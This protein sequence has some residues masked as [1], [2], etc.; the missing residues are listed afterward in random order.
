MGRLPYAN[1]GWFNPIMSVSDLVKLSKLDVEFHEDPQYTQHVTDVVENKNI[2]KKVRKEERCKRKKRLGRAGFGTVWLEQ[3]IVGN[4]EG[5]LRAVKDFPKQGSGDYSR[6]VE[7]IAIFSNQKVNLRLCYCF[8][9][10]PYGLI[11]A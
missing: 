8:L 4:Q 3:C 9:V 6:E 11:I 10:V 2:R 5:E 7:A 1:K